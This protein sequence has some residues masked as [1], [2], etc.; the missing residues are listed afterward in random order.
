M[1]IERD[2][3]RMLHA[4]TATSDDLSEDICLLHLD[5]SV[6]LSDLSVTLS[7]NIKDARELDI[8]PPTP[9]PLFAIPVPLQHF[10]LQL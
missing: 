5:T 9:N 1:Q 6:L 8:A 10:I 4:G 7:G 2:S 3:V